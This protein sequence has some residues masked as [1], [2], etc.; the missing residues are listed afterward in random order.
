MPRATRK[1]VKA[2]ETLGLPVHSDLPHDAVYGLL[3]IRGYLWNGENWTLSRNASDRAYLNGSLRISASLPD[4][5]IIALSLI[6]A[7]AAMGITAHRITGPYPN[8]TGKESRF[9]IYFTYNP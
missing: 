8:K 4:A 3:S 1:Y 9:Y 7:L 2:C 6:D 5:E